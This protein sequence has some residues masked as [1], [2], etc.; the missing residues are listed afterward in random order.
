VITIASEIKPQVGLMASDNPKAVNHQ[1]VFL[2]PAGGGQGRR[3]RS[4]E[5]KC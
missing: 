1:A 3:F 2:T 4:D 5:T